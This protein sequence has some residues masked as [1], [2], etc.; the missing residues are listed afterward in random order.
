MTNSR[1]AIVAVLVPDL[2]ALRVRAAS[3]SPEA[4]S[5][6]ARLIDPSPPRRGMPEP[7]TRCSAPDPSGSRGLALRM[8]RGGLAAPRTARAF[9]RPIRAF[10]SSRSEEHGAAAP[11][12][13]VHAWEFTLSAGA[14]QFDG[15][16]RHVGLDTGLIPASARSSWT[17]EDLSAMSTSKL[18]CPASGDVLSKRSTRTGVLR[19]SMTFFPGYDDPQMPDDV[20]ITH[21]RATTA[22]S[23][24]ATTAA[25]RAGAAPGRPISTQ[26]TGPGVGYLVNAGT[27]G[28]GEAGL[29]VLPAV[30]DRR[31][32]ERHASRGRLRS[33]C[34]RR[35]L[36]ERRGQERRRR[37]VH[38]ARRHD[39]VG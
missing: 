29:P 26:T 5:D 14:L 38:R 36:V 12:V 7:G 4:V 13:Q 3:A 6:H 25:T 1:P 37:S 20:N 19:G 39:V 10:A 17:C 11:P 30:R 16:L 24:R 9:P 32:R 23:T 34:D 33:G 15:E 28:R 35:V 8:D 31:G 22:R 2:G 27:G 18:R 21:V